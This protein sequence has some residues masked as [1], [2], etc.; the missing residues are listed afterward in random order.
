[1]ILLLKHQTNKQILSNDQLIQWEKE[2][3]ETGFI[4]DENKLLITIR[5]QSNPIL[6]SKML[7]V[8]ALSRIN[9]NK[10]DS[11][12]SAWLTK[13][14]ALYP[15]NEK[16][17]SYFIQY[18]WKK[19]KDILDVLTFP[20]IRETDNRTAKKKVAEQYI[21]ICQRFLAEADDQME[22]LTVKRNLAE[23]VG[24]KQLLKQYQGSCRVTDSFH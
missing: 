23:T 15:E 9:R 21:Q 2:L 17:R 6:L 7:T 8:A 1:M 18:D 22:D 13:A 16:A 14:L 19:K 20:A 4:T 10:Q 12:A 3:D 11:L 5:N 24:N